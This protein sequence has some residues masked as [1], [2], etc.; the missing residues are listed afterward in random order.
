M[1]PT[2]DDFHRITFHHIATFHQLGW[3]FCFLF[4]P[5]ATS[6]APPTIRILT[7]GSTSTRLVLTAA[8]GI[9]V[10]GHPRLSIHSILVDGLQTDPG[11][12]TRVL[13]TRC[14]FFCGGGLRPG[15]S[16]E[17]ALRI[18]QHIVFNID[19]IKTQIWVR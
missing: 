4:F 19:G 12:S 1:N 11:R 6:R 9:I 10:P 13:W 2:F 18:V 14:S 15:Q 8:I 5:C 3:T 7:S 16:A 17:V